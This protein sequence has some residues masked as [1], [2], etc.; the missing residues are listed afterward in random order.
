[1][2]FISLLSL[3]NLRITS[4]VFTTYGIL[5]ALYAREKTG[6]GQWVTTSILEATV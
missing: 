6:K 2:A 4:Y 3:R 5:S 1:V